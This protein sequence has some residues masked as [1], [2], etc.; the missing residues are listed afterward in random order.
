MLPTHYNSVLLDRGYAFIMWKIY[1]VRGKQLTMIKDYNR[2]AWVF[3]FFL[4]F[5]NLLCL[6]L[7]KSF[8]V[9]LLSNIFVFILLS[10]ILFYISYKM[11]I[12][13]GV[14]EL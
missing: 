14:D 13:I 6:D 10:C 11:T 12:C 3:F 8:F 5:D 1:N 4:C 7:I 9:Y 2:L